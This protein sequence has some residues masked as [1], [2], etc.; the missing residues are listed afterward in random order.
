MSGRDVSWGRRVRVRV[1]LSGRDVSWGR[2]VRVRVKG[3][4]HVRVGARLGR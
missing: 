3:R 2:R 4:V 1:V